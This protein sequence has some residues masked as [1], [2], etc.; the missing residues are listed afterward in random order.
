MPKYLNAQYR[1]PTVHVAHYH[2]QRVLHGVLNRAA[3]QLLTGEGETH[4]AIIRGKDGE[5]V[6]KPL[7]SEHDA[8]TVVRVQQ[9]GHRGAPRIALNRAAKYLPSGHYELEWDDAAGVARLKV[10]H[11]D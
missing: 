11:A 2:E 9:P 4:V 8:I 6:L 7:W 1:T 3:L 5:I 10:A